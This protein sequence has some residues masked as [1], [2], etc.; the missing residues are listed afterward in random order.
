MPM[1][2]VEKTLI[3]YFLIDLISQQSL[4]SCMC[5]LLQIGFKFRTT[6]IPGIKYHF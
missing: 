1:E 5:L 4:Y 2:G 6:K 3:L